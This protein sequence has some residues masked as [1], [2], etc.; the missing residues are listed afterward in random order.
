MY[1]DQPDQSSNIP[2]ATD[3]SQESIFSDALDTSR[4]DKSLKRA[5]VY[6]YI[7]AG[8]QCAVGIYEYATIRDKDF[9]LVAA[10]IDFGIGAL[11]IFFAVWSY[12]NPVTAFLTALITFVVIHIGMAFFDPASIIR[13]I[14]LK[15]LAVFAL[16]KAYNDAKEAQR[17]R[18]SI[19]GGG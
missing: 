16:I 8:I 2:S 12:K 7:I 14:I 3:T 19:G 5:R 1:S 17:L 13:G 15:G 4:Y 11:F 10:A 6:L 9:A 18:E